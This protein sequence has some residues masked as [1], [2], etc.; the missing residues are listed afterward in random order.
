M[1]TPHEALRLE[2]CLDIAVAMQVHPEGRTRKPQLQVQDGHAQPAEPGVTRV[3]KS[4]PGTCQARRSSDKGRHVRIAADDPV[5]RDDI[6]RLD[7]VRERQEVAGKITDPVGV[8]LPLGFLASD[9]DVGS[10]RIDVDGA[11]GPRSQELVVHGPRATADLE[12]RAPG[13]A[14]GGEDLDERPGQT[15][16]TVRAVSTK[17]PRRVAGVELAIERRVSG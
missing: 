8:A 17:L 3:D 16:G 5:E 13:D 6:D 2:D 12:D 14:A 1:K 10:R 15:G 4:V 11:G 7:L 9:L